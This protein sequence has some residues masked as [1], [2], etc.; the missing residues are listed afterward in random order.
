M[1]VTAICLTD[2]FHVLAVHDA[3]DL[4]KPFLLIRRKRFKSLAGY[5]SRNFPGHIQSDHRDLMISGIF[6]NRTIGRPWKV[7]VFIVD[8]LK[9]LGI[10]V[11]RNPSIQCRLTL[12]PEHFKADG[13]LETGFI[14]SPDN[15]Q[16]HGMVFR[17]AVILAN[18]DNSALF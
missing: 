7:P 4:R 12:F 16:L 18:Q 14:Q 17:I 11:S 2:V 13:Y 8:F 6:K 3:A 1:A 15:A 9:T 5:L 10:D